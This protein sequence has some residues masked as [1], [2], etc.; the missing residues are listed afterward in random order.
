MNPGITEEH[1]LTSVTAARHSR[2]QIL[3]EGYDGLVY[4]QEPCNPRPLTFNK[5]FTQINFFSVRYSSNSCFIRSITSEVWTVTSRANASRPS[6]ATGFSS[7]RFFFASSKN[8][9]AL[10]VL[11]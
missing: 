11:L 10:S 3:S 6:G 1:F 4:F 7:Q 9:G 5:L 2:W 8:S